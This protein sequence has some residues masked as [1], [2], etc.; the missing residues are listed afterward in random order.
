M[1]WGVDSIGGLPG[2]GRDH[3]YTYVS[4]CVYIY[5][6]IYINVYIYIYTKLCTDVWKERERD[7]YIYMRIER[8]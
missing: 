7:I 2:A 3:I 1:G 5:I 8:K 4:T 6:Y